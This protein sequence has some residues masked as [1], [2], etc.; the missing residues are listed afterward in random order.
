MYSTLNIYQNVHTQ[1]YQSKSQ[2]TCAHNTCVVPQII[3]V[4]G[5]FRRDDTFSWTPLDDCHLKSLFSPAS[6]LS[7]RHHYP[8]IRDKRRQCKGNNG[9][10]SGQDPVPWEEQKSLICSSECVDTDQAVLHGLLVHVS[11]KIS[12]CWHNASGWLL[13]TLIP[14]AENMRHW[15][16]SDKH[17]RDFFF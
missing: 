14:L 13:Q 8:R 15:F 3:H 4:L 2:N 12:E 1:I 5:R 11:I 7:L 9:K 6:E 10:A 16:G 17:E